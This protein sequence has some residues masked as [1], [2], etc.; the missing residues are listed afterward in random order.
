MTDKE[1]TT[2]NTK[3]AK[4]EVSSSSAADRHE[5]LAVFLKNL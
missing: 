1:L 5:F 2:S 4:K 3:E